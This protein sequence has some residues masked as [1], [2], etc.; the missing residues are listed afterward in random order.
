MSEERAQY[1]VPSL[2]LTPDE[3]AELRTRH[4]PHLPV[5]TYCHECRYNWPCPTIRAIDQLD[6]PAAGEVERLER[7]VAWWYARQ[8]LATEEQAIAISDLAFGGVTGPAV[9]PILDRLDAEIAAVVARVVERAKAVQ[10]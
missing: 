1:C 10:R 9:Y 6:R 2:D 4:V 8:G 7:L 5:G 3:R